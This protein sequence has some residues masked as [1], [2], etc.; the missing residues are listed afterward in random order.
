MAGFVLVSSANQ[1]LWLNFAPITTGSAHRLGV[2]TSA[3]GVLSE[4]FPLLYVVLAL[5]TGLA[6]DRWFG[7]GLECGAVL[8]AGGAALRLAGHGYPP[9]LIGQLVVAV[10]Q[11]LVLSAVTGLATRSLRPEDRPVGIAVGSA[12]TFLGFVLAFVLG[13]TVGSSRLHLLL[14]ISAVYSIAGTVT[15]LVALRLTP[16][17][18]GR[19]SGG[20]EPHAATG[21]RKEV[22]DLRRV[23]SD[24]VIKSTVIIVF[25]GFGVFVALTTWVQPLLQSS[26]VDVRTA[27]G[28]LIVM[29]AAGIASSVVVPPIV[30]R[31]RAQPAAIAVA[32]VGG[33]AACLMLTAHPG[34]ATGYVALALFGL[35]LLPALPIL[36]ELIEHRTPE[37]AGTATALLW[38]S[39]NAGGLVTAVAVGTLTGHPAV[40]FGLMAAV[41]LVALPLAG[42]LRRQLAP[43]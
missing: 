26:G 2:S 35:V 8:T 1:M 12:G 30:A 6:L 13:L 36:L 5:P 41:A 14:V 21:W 4:V 38:L 33:L 16:L 24:G 39:G 31:R 37:R 42:H 17:A 22:A 43:G 9:V 25:F 18:D 27:D 19:R 20:S 11:P 34:R 32:A 29:V 15:L 3:V 40:A 28:L 7:R 10:G 23:W